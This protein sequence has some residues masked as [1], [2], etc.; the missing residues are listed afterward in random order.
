[1]ADSKFSFAWIGYTVNEWQMKLVRQSGNIGAMEFMHYTFLSPEYEIDSTSSECIMEP[2]FHIKTIN[3]WYV[4]AACV[5][6]ALICKSNPLLRKALDLINISDRKRLFC[7]V[8]DLQFESH[9]A[10]QDPDNPA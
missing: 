7:R 8:E 4:I 3:Y 5:L 6:I 1:M 10:S 2:Q 9:D